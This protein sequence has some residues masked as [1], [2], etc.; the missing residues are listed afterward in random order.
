M[1]ERIEFS[2][3]LPTHVEHF[4]FPDLNQKAWEVYYDN[5]GSYDEHFPD[6]PKDTMLFMTTVYPE[7]VIAGDFAILEKLDEVD[8]K[9]RATSHEPV[10]MINQHTIQSDGKKYWAISFGFSL[11]DIVDE[12]I[13]LS[14]VSST[15]VPM[16]STRP[17]LFAPQTLLYHDDIGIDFTQSFGVRAF[18]PDPI[19]HISGY[20]TNRFIQ[21]QPVDGAAYAYSTEDTWGEL[22]IGNDDIEDYISEHPEHAEVI[23][24]CRDAYRNSGINPAMS[25][26]IVRAFGL[27]D[28]LSDSEKTRLEWH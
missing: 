4:P 3:E 27:D 22:I 14:W 7:K 28:T 8:K 17:V 25:R 9:L 1:N 10:L 5:K 15:A 18:E 24:G 13:D 21:W 23:D 26:S 6:L 19:Q 11:G 16:G 12:H 20:L 2:A